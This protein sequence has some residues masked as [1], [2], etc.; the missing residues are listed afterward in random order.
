MVHKIK[1]A[2]ASDTPG[3][4]VQRAAQLASLRLLSVKDAAGYAKVSTQTVRWWIKSGK[5]KIYR[6][7]RQIRIDE[8]DLID[9]ISP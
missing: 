1:I 2:R 9:H 7:G 6:P 4:R 8:S 3:P 5:L